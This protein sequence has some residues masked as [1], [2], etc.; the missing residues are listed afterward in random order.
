MSGSDEIV[1]EREAVSADGAQVMFDVGGRFGQ[2]E[3]L[4]VIADVDALVERLKALELQEVAQIG[5]ADQDEGE[6]GVRI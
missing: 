3:G 4:D 2:I 5:L 6:S 1:R